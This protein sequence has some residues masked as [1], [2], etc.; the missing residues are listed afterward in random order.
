MTTTQVALLPPGV[1]RGSEAGL[2]GVR[3]IRRGIE[4]EFLE[5]AVVMLTHGGRTHRFRRG[6]TSLN[7]P[8]VRRASI[9]KEVTSRLLRQRGIRAPE[10]AVFTDEARAWAWAEPILP[11]VVKPN[12]ATK[13]HL[14][15]VG[16]ADRTTFAAVFARVTSEY[17]HALVEEQL[18]G[19]EHR[20]AVIGRR[21]AAVTERVPMHVVGDGRSTVA[22][23]V[24]AKNTERRVRRNPIHRRLTVDDEVARTLADS[25]LTLDSIPRAGRT[26]W[27]RRT[28]NISIGGDA[29]DR[30]DQVDPAH[31]TL[32]EQAARAIPGLQVA[33]FDVLIDGDRAAILEIN[34]APMFSI[35]HF[36]WRGE[37]RDV[38]NRLL[39]LM[40]PATA[41]L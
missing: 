37:P 10:N 31:V 16:V 14:V 20:F 12:A 33:G 39:D 15:H 36:P 30:T 6:R 4:V 22:Q 35:H 28:S 24:D 9:Q 41:S 5:N 2:I 19:V 32:V 23:L 38:Y 11:V 13:G 34:T 29:V 7:R 1:K 27:L 3:A 25:G 18:P 17:G 40:F 8:L 21:V 26:V